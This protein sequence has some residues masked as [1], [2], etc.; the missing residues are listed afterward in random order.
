[1]VKF[2]NS[3]VCGI[4]SF[5]LSQTASLC[6]CLTALYP[7]GKLPSQM[8]SV[9]P[10]PG[11]AVS[12]KLRIFSVVGCHFNSLHSILPGR[13][14]QPQN[15][16][17]AFRAEQHTLT[18]G[19]CCHK[20]AWSTVKCSAPLCYVVY[21]SYFSYN[22]CCRLVP[23]SALGRVCPLLS[24]LW[25]REQCPGV[26]MLQMGRRGSESQWAD[27]PTTWARARACSKPPLCTSGQKDLLLDHPSSRYWQAGF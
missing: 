16:F 11:S 8:E 19:M 12:T 4:D 22:R 20:P 18:G 5:F 23:S 3:E 24:S 17:L 13:R 15:H 27:R 1:M 25:P 26:L 9:L 2:F 7:P 21:P 10:N 14:F 6:C